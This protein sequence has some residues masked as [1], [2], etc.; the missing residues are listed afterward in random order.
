MAERDVGHPALAK[1]SRVPKH[2]RLAIRQG[3][4]VSVVNE[5]EARG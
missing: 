2:T 5:T 3:G 1:F 4:G